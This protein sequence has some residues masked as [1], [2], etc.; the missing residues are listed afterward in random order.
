MKR[1]AGL[2]AVLLTTLAAL[3]CRSAHEQDAQPAASAKVAQPGAPKTANA[4]HGNESS[5]LSSTAS[6]AST[7]EGAAADTKWRAPPFPPDDG[8]RVYAKTRYVWIR[9][10]P[11]SSLQWIGYLWYGG[12]AKLRGAKPVY[13]P[14]CDQWYAIEPRGYVCVDGKRATLDRHDREFELIQRYSPRTDQPSPHRYGESLGA[15]RYAALPTAAEQRTRENDL[16]S[17]LKRIEAARQG[18]AD[19]L[20]ENVDLKPANAEPIV[21]PSLPTGLQIPRNTLRSR[22][23]FAYST[24]ADF[25]GRTWLLTA[26]L[27]WMPKDRVTLYPEITF[28]GVHLDKD[29]QLPIALFR[30]KARPQYKKT[31]DGRFA[32]TA[33]Q[34]ERLSFV[35]LTGA[36]E[37][38]DDVVYLETKLPGIYVAES[39]A[40]VPTPQAK[41]PWG[42][43]VGKAD[44]TPAQPKGRKTW[45]EASVYGGWLIA[46]EG[47]SPVF[48]TLISPGRGGI[49]VEGK[50]PV[51]TASTPIGRFS[52]TGKFITAT[53]EAP[54]ELIHSDVPW[55]QNFSGPHAVHGAYWHNDWGDLKSGGCI[56]V[57]PIDGKWLFSFTEP[58]IPK[59][60]HAVRWDPKSEPST[61]VIVHR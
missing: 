45:I 28:R 3:G 5:T 59:D 54:H 23:A 61:T 11:D 38:V 6:F 10:Y 58:L 57:S 42:A 41:T 20:L 25:E 15:E 2:H 31:P 36:K 26:D 55:T 14:G 56:N 18:Q 40:V 48:T 32:I 12:S 35:P 50:N 47:T 60:W 43:E 1:R 44:T 33:Q 27:M 30:R 4:V 49:P 9:P 19:A 53:M 21:F 16:T 29:V 22:S 52:I 7:A 13:G 51:E 24:E 37:T 34:F 46:Y 17:H 39:D 8:P